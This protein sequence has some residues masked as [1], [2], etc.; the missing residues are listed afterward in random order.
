MGEG[1]STMFGLEIDKFRRVI[2]MKNYSLVHKL[3][4]EFPNLVFE[5]SLNI[6]GTSSK[7]IVYRKNP[8]MR[9][10][11]TKLTLTSSFIDSCLSS[12]DRIYQAGSSSEKSVREKLD[13]LYSYIFKKNPNRECLTDVA[14]FDTC[15][16]AIF[17]KCTD[18]TEMWPF[19]TRSLLDREEPDIKDKLL[20]ALIYYSLEVSGS[21]YPTIIKNFAR[22]DDL[23][24]SYISNEISKKKGWHY[25]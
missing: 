13:L 12:V 7:L 10:Y 15:I 17:D 5:S 19:Y 20:D 24:S 6:N 23:L 1:N 16:N 2:R 4:E 9:M 8:E 11:N 25:F 18:F 3:T 14:I 22:D 21:T